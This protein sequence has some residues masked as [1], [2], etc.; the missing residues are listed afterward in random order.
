[1]PAGSLL[2]DSPVPGV[3]LTYRWRSDFICTIYVVTRKPRVKNTAVLCGHRVLLT[4]STVGN[5]TYLLFGFPRELQL[6]ERH[7]LT[8]SR[9]VD[10]ET[11]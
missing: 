6:A 2:A 5:N 3:L 8:H 10:M 9:A 1:M 4:L 7:Y 11:K